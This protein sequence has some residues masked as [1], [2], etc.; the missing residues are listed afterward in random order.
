MTK[1]TAPPEIKENKL[2]FM[3]VSKTPSR[4][5]SSR[6]AYSE[7]LNNH[8]YRNYRDNQILKKIRPNGVLAEMEYQPQKIELT[9]DEIHDCLFKKPA[10]KGYW[11]YCDEM[12]NN[13]IPTTRLWDNVHTRDLDAR[14]GLT[15]FPKEF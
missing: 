2:K 10:L 11:K 1:T 13:P 15:H 6:I 9:V 14:I 5:Q 8:G 12:S 3:K 7:R 4:S